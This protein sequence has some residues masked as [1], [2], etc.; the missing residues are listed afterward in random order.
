M[1]RLAVGLSFS[2]IGLAVLGCA[3]TEGQAQVPT[4]GPTTAAASAPTA[5]SAQVPTSTASPASPAVTAGARAANPVLSST[6]P[7]PTPGALNCGGGATPSATEGPYY[8]ARS[9]ERTSLVE[10][11]VSGM[12]LTLTGY[13]LTKDCKPVSGA[14]LDF[15]QANGNGEYDNAGYRLRGFQHTDDTGRYFLETV[16]P[17]EYP[18]RTVHIHVKVQ[19]PGRQVL[20]TQLYLPDYPLNARDSIFTPAT[21]MQVVDGPDGKLATFNFVLDIR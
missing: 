15:W 11:G 20:T 18:G 6:M 21:V 16:V 2:V 3:T 14:W 17:G 8:K 13:V 1:F 4:S 12:K 9:P 19:A 5:P 7:T 10:E